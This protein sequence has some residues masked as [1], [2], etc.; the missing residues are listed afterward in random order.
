[1]GSEI[2]ASAKDKPC[3][4]DG[5]ESG[6]YKT[7]GYCKRHY[8]RLLRTGEVGAVEKQHAVSYAGMECA[9]DDCSEVPRSLGFCAAHYKRFRRWGDPLGSRPVTDVAERFWGKVNKF[10]PVPAHRPGLGP[11][12]IWTAGGISK[13][14]GSFDVSKVKKVLAHRWAYQ[15]VYGSITEGL[16]IDHLC[17]NRR[18]VNPSHLEEVTNEENLRRGAGYGLQNGMRD[19][20]IHGHQ[21]TPENSYY[22]P[23]RGEIRCRQCAKERATARK[24]ET[25]K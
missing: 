10:G 8:A 4:V 23:K 13:G 11:C 3:A 2:R 24:T 21:Y 14:Y 19:H 25:Q 22:S 9:V 16:V 15:Q 5:C 20:C 7:R 1:M 12:W 6:G 17:R 18:C